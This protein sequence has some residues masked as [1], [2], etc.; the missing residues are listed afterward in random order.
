MWPRA[1]PPVWRLCSTYAAHGEEV[2]EGERGRRGEQQV[3][4]EAECNGE[5]AA[6]AHGAGSGG[7]GDGDG[8]DQQQQARAVSPDS[9]SEY[10]MDDVSPG[11]IHGKHLWCG[12]VWFLGT[13]LWR[14]FWCWYIICG[15][16]RIERLTFWRPLRLQ[17]FFLGWSHWIDCFV[18]LRSA[19]SASTWK[20]GRQTFHRP[21][22]CL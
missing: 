15:T 14:P 12:T 4:R 7:G 6:G 22:G 3:L 13:I 20:V 10:T 1:S 16:I 21:V 11:A 18:L 8:G 19:V 17:R 2:L 5:T 9:F